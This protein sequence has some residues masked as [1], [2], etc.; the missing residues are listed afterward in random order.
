ME[1]IINIKKDFINEVEMQTIV[2]MAIKAYF[3]GAES[4]DETDFI[5][6]EIMG[7]DVNP[8]WADG[9]FFRGVFELCSDGSMEY[10]EA[11]NNGFVEYSLSSIKNVKYAYDK[12]LDII[13]N[14][15]SLENIINI[16][17][18]HL[19]DVISTKLPEKEE[20]NKLLKQIPKILKNIDLEQLK[21]VVGIN[22]KIS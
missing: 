14:M 11:F 19:I 6:D 8:M 12:Y 22:N 4:N 15:N 13:K 10:N 2:A 1:K 18:K 5:K 9:I 17:L 3:V 21:D 16:N 7:L 20:M